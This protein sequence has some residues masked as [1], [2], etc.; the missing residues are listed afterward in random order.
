MAEE[1][2]SVTAARYVQELCGRRELVDS[3]GSVCAAHLESRALA[4]LQNVNASSFVELVGDMARDCVTLPEWVAGDESL[5]DEDGEFTWIFGW[6][7]AEAVAAGAAAVA[8]LFEPEVQAVPGFYEAAMEVLESFGRDLDCL[9]PFLLG[10]L[11]RAESTLSARPG[12]EVIQQSLQRA[13]AWS[14]AAVGRAV[15]FRRLSTADVLWEW[16][17][18]EAA[19][20]LAL[21]K[22]TLSMSSSAGDRTSLEAPRELE[23]LQVAVASAVLGLGGATVA[24]AKDV[25]VAED[26]PMA[27][28]AAALAVHRAKLAEE[29]VRM[30]VLSVLLAVAAGPTEGAA[31]LRVQLPS[32]LV[33]LL[34]PELVF[35][36]PPWALEA[37]EWRWA[38]T[39][40]RQFSSRLRSSLGWHSEELWATLAR[41]P[42]ATR[43]SLSFL[44]D[45]SLLAACAG[46]A[47]QPCERLLRACVAQLMLPDVENPA[48]RAGDLTALCALATNAELGPGGDGG[49]RE[50]IKAMPAAGH[51]ALAAHFETWKEPPGKEA[52]GDWLVPH[53]ASTAR[54]PPEPPAEA[55]SPQGISAGLRD[56]LPAAPA[57]ICCALDGRLLT[58]PVRAPWGGP[59]YERSVLVLHLAS[60]NCCPR[61]GQPLTIVMCQRD[62]GLRQQAL[63]WLRAERA[64]KQGR[65]LPPA[66]SAATE[67]A[68]PS[69]PNFD[70]LFGS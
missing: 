67:A 43:P 25:T 3:A 5:Q 40:S 45:C 53:C 49:L 13:C 61:T 27:E 41:V 59:A 33:H 34:Q 58:D 64:G 22:G 63:Q 17:T 9:F 4:V 55:T 68:P 66:S 16:A 39:A 44:R 54:P 23:E 30:D 52:L 21:A 70:A 62:V 69:A 48:Q 31:Q 10:G 18:G 7:A 8:G 38:L 15:G 56:R 47:T 2:L 6:A 46:A 12:R 29:L 26:A 1:T 11:R 28:R 65:K 35:R 51:A 14:L 20:A 32:F 50:L 60:S 19:W 57:E 42:T 37:S 24:F 36:D